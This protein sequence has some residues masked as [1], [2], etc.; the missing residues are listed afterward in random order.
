MGIK[1]FCILKNYETV[2]GY[3]GNLAELL[4]TPLVI[5][6]VA[7]DNSGF[8]I[9]NKQHTAMADVQ[10][11]DVDKYFL[12]EIVCGV[13]LPPNLTQEQKAAGVAKRVSRKGGY[14]HIVKNIVIAAS[15]ATGVFNDDFLFEL[16]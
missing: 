15:L 4:N 8:L 10:M 9:L 11:S 6:D 12:C 16:Q 1:G 3:R 5:M 13:V 7:V 2:R 14:N